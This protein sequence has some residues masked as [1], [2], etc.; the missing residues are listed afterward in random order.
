MHLLA[1]LNAGFQISKKQ[2]QLSWAIFKCISLVTDKYFIYTSVKLLD[3]FQMF[4]GNVDFSN[5]G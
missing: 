5:I 1:Y 2:M 4:Y 3:S